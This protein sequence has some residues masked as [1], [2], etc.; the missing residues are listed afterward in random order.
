MPFELL[1][2][3][4]SSEQVSPSVSKFMR[5]PF[6]RSAWNCS[7]PP[8]P[9]ATISAGFYRQQLQG[10]LSTA[11]EPWAVEPAV[12]QGPIAPLGGGGTSAAEIA[13]LIFNGHRRVWDQTT[14][15]LCAFYQSQGSFFYVSVGVGLWFSSTSG[16][17]Q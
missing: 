2:Q 3:P 10:L 16:T 13:F 6:K 5:G 11:L 8:A 7:S 1:A 15:C 17:S 14:L 12:G 9:S 4:W